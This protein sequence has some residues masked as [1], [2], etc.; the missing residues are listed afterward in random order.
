MLSVVF[1][2]LSTPKEN[3]QTVAMQNEVGVHIQ[4]MQLVELIWD[5]CLMGQIFLH[6]SYC[7]MT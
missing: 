6:I 1:F 4:D 5:I 2:Y 7:Q 3:V